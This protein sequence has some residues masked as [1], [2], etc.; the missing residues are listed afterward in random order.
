[1]SPDGQFVAFVSEQA[2]NRDIWIKPLSGGDEIQVTHDAADD[3]DP[4]WSPDGS[5]IV[6][7]SYRGTGGLYT[8]PAFGGSAIR[9]NDFGY[10]PR[11]S[12]DGTRILFQLRLGQYIPNEIYIRPYPPSGPAEAVLPW[13]PGQDPYL[14]ADWSPDGKA[15]ILVTGSYVNSPGLA[16]LPLDPRGPLEFVQIDGRNVSGSNPV[17]LA[18]RDGLIFRSGGSLSYVGLDPRDSTQAISRGRLTTATDSFPEVSRDGG[19]LVYNTSS[20]QRDIWRVRLAPETGLPVEDPVRI[21]QSAA[22][23]RTPVVLPDDSHFLFLSNRDNGQYLY[24]ADLDG[25]N[26][27][28]VDRSTRWNQ[29][30][31]VSPDGRLISLMKSGPFE[32]FL[33]PFDPRN[34]EALGPPK[35]FEVGYGANSWT[36]DN[37]LVVWWNATNVETGNGRGFVTVE[38]PMGAARRSVDWPLSPGFVEGNPTQLGPRPSPDGRWLAFGARGSFAQAYRGRDWPSIFVVAQ[39]GG[40]PTLV[41]EGSVFVKW[42]GG[43]GRLHIWSQRGDETAERLGFIDIDPETGRPVG[44]FRSLDLKPTSGYGNIN[45]YSMTSDGQW[46]FFAWSHV[47]GDLYIADIEQGP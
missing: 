15:L 5:T 40:E 33:L 27:R 14:E 23:D 38:D 24:V 2:G 41:W 11:W 18:N 46:L 28:L 7:R 3:F 44:E 34:L 31:S 13:E 22:D 43:P 30:T 8:V 10:R 9:F 29:A 32:P 19:R 37:R 26:V 1:M 4:D 17:W 35:S 45:E 12:P 21:S 25:E 20:T 47:E 16:M 6:F 42:M 39:G 36:P